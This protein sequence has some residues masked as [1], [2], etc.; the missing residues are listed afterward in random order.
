MA[1]DAVITAMM[2]RKA[3]TGGDP[4]GRWKTNTRIAVPTTPHSP[5]PIPPTR[6]PSTIAPMTTHA[7]G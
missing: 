7:A 6:T 5:S 2:M 4:G 3:S 1:D